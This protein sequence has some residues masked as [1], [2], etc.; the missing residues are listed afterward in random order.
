MFEGERL[1]NALVD[2]RTTA[3]VELRRRRGKRRA[4]ILDAIVLN[5]PAGER[6]EGRF[7]VQRT[8]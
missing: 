2:K 5:E 8:L 6:G 7:G 4:V 1:E 3:G